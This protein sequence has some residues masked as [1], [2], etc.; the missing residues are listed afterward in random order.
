MRLKVL[1]IVGARPQ[2][3]KA[4]VV[5][6]AIRKECA[7][8]LVHTGQHYDYEMSGVFFEDLHLPEADYHLGVGSDSHAK[9]TGAMLIGLEDVIMLEKP[10]W[11]LVYGDTNSTLA[12]A[13]AASKLQ[14]P[15]AHVEAGLRSFNRTMPEE[16]NRVIADRLSQLLFCPSSVAL[17]NLEAEGI[18][19]GVHMVGD[20]MYDAMRRFLPRIKDRPSLL[21]RIRATPGEYSLATIHRAENTDNPER[22]AAILDCLEAVEMQVVFPAHPRT[23]DALASNAFVVPDNVELIDPVGYLDMLMLEKDA[24][25]I[26]TDSGGI[27]KEAFWLRVP[28]ITLRD[29]TEWVET[30]ETGWN[31]TVGVDPERVRSALQRPKP[32][33]SPPPV[34]GD[35]KAAAKIAKLIAKG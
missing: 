18:T 29:E 25:A 15:L 33:E 19:D 12:G 6:S 13:L 16:I 9:Q 23:K 10:D 4:V 5:S 31:E 3:I 21:E 28:C 32:E 35:G 22:L 14:I 8:V 7:E 30:V 17:R 27:Q 26:L 11:V 20:V 24:Y 34:Y 1:S 2:F